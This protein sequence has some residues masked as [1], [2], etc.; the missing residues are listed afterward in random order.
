MAKKGICIVLVYRKYKEFFPYAML[1]ESLTAKML[2]N[3]NAEA[4]PGH[5]V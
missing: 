1:R 2:Y 3:L 4:S 5:L